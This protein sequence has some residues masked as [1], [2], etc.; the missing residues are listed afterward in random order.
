MSQTIPG[1][2]NNDDDKKWSFICLSSHVKN[3]LDKRRASPIVA[4]EQ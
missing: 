3:V 1:D 4:S 2:H